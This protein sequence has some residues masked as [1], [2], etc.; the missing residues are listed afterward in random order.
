[1]AKLREDG[2][3]RRMVLYSVMLHLF[4]VVLV[5]LFWGKSE[6]PRPRRVQLTIESRPVA[7][8]VIAEVRK[9]SAPGRARVDS[10]TKGAKSE[11]LESLLQRSSFTHDRPLDRAEPA[12]RRTDDADYGAL[13]RDRE[14]PYGRLD[15][16]PDARDMLSHRP[17]LTE[18][19]TAD[20]RGAL[21]TTGRD[22]Y[23][24]QA[25]RDGNPGLT[26]DDFKRQGDQGSGVTGTVKVR[27]R[28]LVYRPEIQLPERYSRMG[29]SFSVQV[30]IS[31][32]E[33]GLVSM[34]RVLAS[35]GDPELDRRLEQRARLFRFEKASTGGVQGGT[36]VFD[37]QPR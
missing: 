24:R 19:D 10:F 7:R 25:G 8:E 13:R 18:R 6:E 11:S 14:S 31:V 3:M 27:G 26:G 9:E 12:R 36:I 16:N 2:R 34:A 37:I 29:L 22:D 1:M 4:L 23:T 5:S 33:E 15:R 35:S 17:G 20:R 21:D 32:T 28:S 30:E